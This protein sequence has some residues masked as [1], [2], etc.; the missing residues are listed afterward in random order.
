MNYKFECRVIDADDQVVVRDWT[1][2]D[3]DYI[4]EFGGNE[5]V[6]MTVGGVLRAVKRVDRQLP[7]REDNDN[8]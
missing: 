4:D 7:I 1:I 6:D 5:L 2:L 3:A 8:D